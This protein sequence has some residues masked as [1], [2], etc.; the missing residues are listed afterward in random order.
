MTSN[1][2]LEGEE[3]T[4]DPMGAVWWARERV[5]IVSDLHFE[6]GSA[7]ASKGVMLPPYD[8]R[9]TLRRVAVLVDRYQPQTVLSLGDAFHDR[10][11]EA[12]MDEEDATMLAA[13]TQRAD[14]QWVLGNHDPAPPARFAGNACEEWSR[15][16][17]VFRHEALVNGRP[18]EISGHYHPCAKVICEGRSLRRRCFAFDG[19]RL[20]MPAMGAYTGGLNILDSAYSSILRKRMAYVM[21]RDGVYPIG[22]NQLAPD[23]TI[24]RRAG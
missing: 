22:E 4:L 10:D 5:L 2:T 8:T 6:K 9:T 18:G 3:L 20:I 12:R 14:W 23:A 1:L 7:F 17:L 21:G 19:Q 24:A 15:N 13:L 11:A 16:G